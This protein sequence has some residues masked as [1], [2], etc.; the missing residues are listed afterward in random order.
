MPKLE[1]K[2]AVVTGATSGIGLAAARLLAAEG[3]HVYITGRRKDKL[4]QAVAGID[5]T[6]PGAVTGVQADSASPADLD[7]LFETVKDGHG[8]VDVLYA[9]AGSASLTE[10]LEAVTIASFD[11][12]FGV[13]VRGTL[14][15]VQKAV[16]LM[17][18]GG[19][20]ILNSSVGGVKGIPGSTV[21][22]ASKVALR[23][24]VR[25][26]TAE[27]AERGIRFNLVSAG[28]VETAAWDGTPPEIRA[29]VT[30]M[31]PAGRFGSD[32]QARPAPST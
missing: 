15:T 30:A 3:A 31:I 1:G 13:N 27:L 26:W 20:V 32:Q 17:T 12:V 11:D 7:R 4:A 8:R 25:T 5:A 14:F 23:S 9:N 18:A 29:A 24:F 22:A 10:P 6:V 28:P 2:V 16:P 19:S 21:Y